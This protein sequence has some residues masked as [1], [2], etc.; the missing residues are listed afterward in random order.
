[1]A[2]KIWQSPRAA[3]G[4]MVGL[5][6]TFLVSTPIIGLAAPHPQS[7]ADKAASLPAPLQ[8]AGETELSLL[9]EPSLLSRSMADIASA[10]SDD[11][12]I[13]ETTAGE[14]AE[15]TPTTEP[16]PAE[17]QAAVAAAPE[18]TA[19]GPVFI[20]V[21]YA[22][23]VTANRLNLRAEPST[24]AASLAQMKYGDKVLCI[25]ENDEWMQVEAN[26]LTGYLKTEY[27]S[28]M[29]IFKPVMETV[30]V[31]SNTLNLRSEPSTDASIVEKLVK[32][33]PLTRTGIG[34]QWSKVTSMS[35]KQGYVY[36]EYLSLQPPFTEAITYS[37][38]D[39]SQV[40]QTEIDLLMKIVYMEAGPSSSYNGYLAVASV[41]LNRVESGRFSNTITGVISAP[42][43]FTT[44]LIPRDP[45]ISDTARRAVTDALA[46]K[47]IMPK[48]V[49]YFMDA[50]SYK[51]NIS[52]GGSFSRL[53]LYTIAYGNAW[54][55]KASDR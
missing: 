23:Y 55:Y 7:T 22:L 45:V 20:A 19:G 51:H 13:A 37:K 53:V 16:A 41:I 27:T 31:S 26:G 21:K 17:T 35:G 46:G 2:K 32:S 43:Q 11:P 4:M 9:T 12:G 48:Y 5:W 3:C 47:R 49:L 33:E 39:Y 38:A 1:M 18:P 25:G 30:F 54:F 28:K 52:E 34:D 15:P 8:T 29:M 40:D 50:E 36:T 6:L 10:D 44:Y 42:N 24:D 14:T